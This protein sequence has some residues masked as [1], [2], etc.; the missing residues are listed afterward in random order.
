MTV[1]LSSFKRNSFKDITSSIINSIIF[2]R[3]SDNL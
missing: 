2:F 3:D 1:C